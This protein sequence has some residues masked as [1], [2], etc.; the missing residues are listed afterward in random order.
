ME[1]TKRRAVIFDVDGTLAENMDGRIARHGQKA[2]PFQDWDAYDDKVSEEVRE[3]LN[4]YK[5]KYTIIICSGRKDSSK[6]VLKDWL[7][8]NEIHYDE[9]FM[10][11][12]KDNRADY[13]IKEEIY[14]EKI[15]PFYEV[16]TAF[17]DRKQVVDRWRELG[18]KTFQVEPGDF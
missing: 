17:D 7:T 14:L 10:R 11:R 5:E 13:L 15:Q 8:E 3:A 9:I 18:I 6:D 2:A 16:F 4:L 1:E 12:H